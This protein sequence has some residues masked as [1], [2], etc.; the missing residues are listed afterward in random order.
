[1]GFADE[2]AAGVKCVG[3]AAQRKRPGCDPA[4]RIE[5]QRRQMALRTQAAQ[6]AGEALSMPTTLPVKDLKPSCHAGS[7][8]TGL[9]TQSMVFFEQRCVAAV[10]LG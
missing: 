3:G 7:L 8:L 1:M 4:L 6:C 5:Q 2:L 9:E 10:V